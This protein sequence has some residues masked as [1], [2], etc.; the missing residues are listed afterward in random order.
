MVDVLPLSEGWKEWAQGKGKCKEAGFGVRKW[1][2]IAAGAYLAM[3]FQ[4][5]KDGGKQTAI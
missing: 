3:K 4:Q 1:E 5:S 2:P